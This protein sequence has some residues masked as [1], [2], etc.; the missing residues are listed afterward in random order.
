MDKRINDL[1]KMYMDV[2]IPDD[3]DYI[4]DEAVKK[5]EI[6]M[7][8]KLK[9]NLIKGISSIAAVFLIFAVSVNTIPVFANSMSD[10]PVIGKLVQ[11]LQFTD[12]KAQGGNMTDGVDIGM[13]SLKKAGNSEEVI[14]KFD[15]SGDNI[16]PSYNIKYDKYPYSMIFTVSGVRRFSAEKDFEALKYSSL[17]SDS[18]N[19]ITLDDSA[20]RFAINFKKPVKY[21]VKEYKE[22][23]Q[24]VI[25]LK[26]DKKGGD[27]A[28]YIVR[29]NSYPQGETLGI[30]EE[31]LYEFENIKIV[32]DDKGT[33]VVEAG[34]FENEEKAKERIREII[35]KCGSDIKLYV[36]KRDAG[37]LPK[38]IH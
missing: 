20:V 28:S 16:A 4:I 35:N 7:K 25:S 1:K 22:P 26:E 3:I 10:V 12:N 14:I 5:G 13:I 2:K 34:A 21:E 6:K 33:F 9:I 19:I 8:N 15:K 29:T 32:K 30:L 27:K 38:Q 31:R 17:I 23:A 37:Q 24:I 18:Y 36:E 11:V